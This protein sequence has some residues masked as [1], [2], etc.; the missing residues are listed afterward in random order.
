MLQIGYAAPTELLEDAFGTPRL[1]LAAALQR[2]RWQNDAARMTFSRILPDD[3]PEDAAMTTVP[4][5]PRQL[6]TVPEDWLEK[7]L[8]ESLAH[9]PSA[10]GGWNRCS[11]GSARRTAMSRSSRPPSGRVRTPTCHPLPRYV[12][13]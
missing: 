13:F 2:W 5:L 6:V 11:T 7:W 4:V 8:P 3:Y 9:L 12:P 10:S 1:L